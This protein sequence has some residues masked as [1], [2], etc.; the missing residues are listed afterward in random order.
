VPA[1][2]ITEVLAGDADRPRAGWFENIPLQVIP[3]FSGDARWGEESRN[4]YAAP[5]LFNDFLP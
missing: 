3:L 2:L 1:D 4:R 5:D